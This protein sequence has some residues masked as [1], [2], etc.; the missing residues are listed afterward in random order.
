M[1]LH[2]QD[3]SGLTRIALQVI[4]LLLLANQIGRLNEFNP[5]VSYTKAIDCWT[6][7]S[8]TFIMIAV[9][10]SI[11]AHYITKRGK[12]SQLNEVTPKTTCLNRWNQFTAGGKLDLIMR[13]IFPIVF[14]L[15]GILYFACYCM[16]AK[17][18]M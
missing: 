7:M 13:I 18:A 15:Y 14:L 3:T 2:H 11:I 17:A 9:I 10:E 1:F 6:G 5:I 16:K 12:N 4:T 8:L